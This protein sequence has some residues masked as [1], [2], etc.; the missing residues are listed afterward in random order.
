MENRLTIFQDLLAIYKNLSEIVNLDCWET[1]MKSQGVKGRRR[2][3]LRLWG[4]REARRRE[5][6]A[7]D[8]WVRTGIGG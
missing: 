7:D 3:R 2:M 1:A 5:Q 4:W 6:E 8:P